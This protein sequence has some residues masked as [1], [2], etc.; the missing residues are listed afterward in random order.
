M[1]YTLRLALFTLLATSALVMTVNAENP[2]V[3]LERE[4]LEDAAAKKALCNDGTAPVYYKRVNPDSK[5]WFINLEG[6]AFCY[7]LY[8]CEMR[9]LLLHSFTTGSL[10][11]T[12]ATMKPEGL[13]S[14]DCKVNPNFCDAN[15]FYLHYCS[16]D[17]HAGE[18]E[19][20]W[21]K[22][23]LYFHG[24]SILEHFIKQV[25][26]KYPAMKEAE[27]VIL[28]GNSAGAEGAQN[29]GDR[30]GA[31]L[32]DLI[33]THD[34]TYRLVPDSGWIQ[35]GPSLYDYG[36]W[37]VMI[38]NQDYMKQKATTYTNWQLDDSCVEALGPEDSYKCVYMTEEGVLQ[39]IE[40]PAFFTFYLEDLA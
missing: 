2:V 40:T 3:L 24:K 25:A 35:T 28:S 20:T 10:D 5:K 19:R 11:V 29:N 27:L 33:T 14:T 23:T 18:V 30:V 31:L 12:P 22:G 13:F 38:C 8:S 6:G 9:H 4:Q 39:Y 36:C 15:I 37:F 7:D 26:A 1:S 32:R 17:L 16:S 21:S 34:F